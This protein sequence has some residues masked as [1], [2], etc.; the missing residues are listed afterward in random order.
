MRY[1]MKS[2]NIIFSI[3]MLFIIIS[4]TL[5]VS[6]AP[7]GMQTISGYR[8]SATW[9]NVGEWSSV[10]VFLSETKTNTEIVIIKCGYS[11]DCNTYK[12][13][14][15]KDILKIDGKLTKATVDFD[16]LHIIFNGYGSIIKTD[17][18]DDLLPFKDT[19][20][21]RNSIVT[22]TLNGIILGNSSY[23]ILTSFKTTSWLGSE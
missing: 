14:T 18:S 23:G 8:V 20:K 10:D 1:I 3:L 22:G 5:N 13:S 16:R 6:S 7:S 4:T 15:K 17:S 12:T 2:R 11:Y 19:T 9:K 21:S